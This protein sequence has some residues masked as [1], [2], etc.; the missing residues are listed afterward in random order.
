MRKCDR[1]GRR[2][3]GRLL[4]VTAAVGLMLFLGKNKVSPEQISQPSWRIWQAQEQAAG[5][6]VETVGKNL[7]LLSGV[8]MSA[9]SEES[10]SF[11]AELA[12]DGISQ[13]AALRWSSENDWENSDHWLQAAF[14]ETQTVGAV[15]IFWERT[16][17]Q[18]YALEYSQDGKSWETAASFDEPPAGQEQRIVLEQPVEAKYLRL[19]VTEVTRR[20]DDLSLYYQNISVL[21][22]EAYAGISDSFFVETPQIL[23]GT[24]RS[25]AL[26]DVPERYTLTFVG[27]DYDALVEE[28][29]KIADTVGT[30]RAELGFALEKDSVSWELPGMETVIPSSEGESGSEAEAGSETE[31]DREAAA[32]LP[33]GFSAMEWQP[34]ENGAALETEGWETLRVL[35]PKGQEQLAGTAEL[36]ARELEELLGIPV[37]AG[38]AVLSDEAL[39]PSATEH[40]AEGLICLTLWEDPEEWTQTLGEEGC[41]LELDA[42]TGK[43]RITGRTARGVRWGCVS[44]L[45]L[46]EKSGGQ[47]PEGVLRDY[48]RYRVRGF[49]ID[50]GRRPVSLQLL[51]R[52][53]EELSARRMNTLL[54]HLNDN[55]IISQSGYNGTVEGAYG[56]YAG[57]R[58]ESEIQNE[59]GQGLTS[60]DLFYT[61]EEFA[62]FIEDAATYG[63]EVV[64]EIDTPAHSLAITKL[65]PKLGLQGNPEAADQ[66]DLSNPDSIAL[67]KEIW[68]EYLEGDQPVFGETR[69]LHIGMDEYFGDE[70]EYLDYVRELSSYVEGLAP[71]KTIRMWGSLSKTGGARADISRNIQLHI[72]DTDWADPQEMYEAGF[73]LIN[74]LSSSLYLIPGGGYDRL[75]MDFLRESWQPNVF[76]TAERTWSLPAY[77]PQMLGACYMMWNDWAQS[78]GETITEE[79]LFERFLEPLE[80]IAGKLWGEE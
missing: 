80:V 17:A 61:K 73:G 63:V 13:D 35:Y 71:N 43:V 51:Y 20:E 77:S 14:R 65:F 54:V 74:S 7:L 33:E 19:H 70:E 21:E 23:E 6:Q 45:E 76:E 75:D 8:R 25:L 36:F 44:F 47:L 30:A 9:D 57:F 2:R 56:L 16:N 55:Q 78:G 28:S 48:P 50:V 69:A 32:A 42:E 18:R 4:A 39:Q 67:V 22:L 60:E 40:F 49:G 1:E 3:L 79:G 27:A 37:Y 46:W 72:W 41:E 29:G 58:L 15:R 24:G 53:V 26:P 59:A 66:L 64:P 38:E 5:I 34:G 31:A 12:R 11:G 68:K 62:Q 52:M 10:K